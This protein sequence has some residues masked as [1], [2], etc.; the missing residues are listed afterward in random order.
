MA[1]NHSLQATVPSGLRLSSNQASI[2][3]DLLRISC[4]VPL[5][6]LP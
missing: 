2:L 1:A 5:P 3:P 4:K 6:G